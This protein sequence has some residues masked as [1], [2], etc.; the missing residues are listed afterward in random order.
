MF[1]REKCAKS[2][3]PEKCD[4]S[5]S[6]VKRRLDMKRFR[7]VA[8]DGRKASHNRASLHPS[9]S[10]ISIPSAIIQSRIILRT[11]NPVWETRVQGWKAV[12]SV[13]DDDHSADLSRKVYHSRMS[14][15]NDLTLIQH[16]ISSVIS[17]YFPVNRLKTI[18]RKH[19]L[20]SKPVLKTSLHS[21]HSDKS[22]YY[23]GCNKKTPFG[24]YQTSNRS[25]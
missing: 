10:E 25:A 24:S 1:S 11:I 20:P 12:W 14:L 15:E 5:Q 8:L 21:A 23:L 22:L 2:I 3:F 9:F 18:W 13:R 7:T 19:N 6:S 4:A 16:L 17:K